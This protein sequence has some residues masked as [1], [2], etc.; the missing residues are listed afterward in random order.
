MRNVDK[1]YHYLYKTTNLINGK[2]YYGMHSTNNINDSYLG[3]GKRLRYSIRKYGKDNFKRE[4]IKMFDS[5]EELVQGEIDLITNDLVQDKL[6][7]N[8]K[9]GG[10]GGLCGMVTVKDK[11]GNCFNIF[12]DDPRYLSGEVISVASNRVHVKDKD[13]NSLSVFRDDLRYLSGELLS[14]SINHVTVKDKNGNIL[15]IFK[16]GPPSSNSWQTTAIPYGIS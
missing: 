10:D 4:I 13:G 12:K 6:C 5:R 8:L 3:S 2:Y 16:I 15:R 1:K 7:M 9:P 11:N 14:A